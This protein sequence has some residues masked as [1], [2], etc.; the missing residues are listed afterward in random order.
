MGNSQCCKN[1]EDPDAPWVAAATPAQVPALQIAEADVPIVAEE[2][3][4]FEPEAETADGVGDH[5][6]AVTGADAS[7]EFIKKDMLKKLLEASGEDLGRT[8]SL[9]PDA[10]DST[11]KQSVGGICCAVSD[12]AAED[13]PLVFVSAGFQDLTGYTTDFTTGRNCRFLQPISKI[14]NDAFNIDDRTEMRSFCVDPQPNG[15]TIVNLLVNENA[16]TGERFWNLLRMQYIGVED[17]QYIFGV[18]TTIDAYMPKSLVKRLKNQENNKK[19]VDATEDFRFHLTRIRAE[20][21]NMAH[22]PIFEVKGF[23]TAMLNHVPMVMKLNAAGMS[24]QMSK[25]VSSAVSESSVHAT[26]ALVEGNKVELLADVKYAS[27]ALHTG[28]Q[29]EVKS[30]DAF[31]NVAIAFPGGTRGV[32]KRDLKKLKRID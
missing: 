12:P 7:D 6:C 4:V 28:E 32:L 15:K 26:E 30:I 18:Q 16:I 10:L 31:G 25:Q 3:A 27:G 11:Q 24:K 19:V 14:V 13:C 17:R 8:F 1:K 22:A 5:M 2:P 9:S 23:F 20:L 21:K 29:G